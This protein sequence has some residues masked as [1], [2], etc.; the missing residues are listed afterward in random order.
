MNAKRV[1]KRI[2]DK[3]K[4]IKLIAMD[5]DGVLTGGEILVYECG[6]KIKELKVWNVRD[7][8]GFS[9]LR[10][11]K[12]GLKLAWITGR[13]C[14]HVA[15]QAKELRIEAF[16]QDC[17]D[18]GTAMKG[19]MKKFSL[20]PEQVLYIGDDLVDVPV[21]KMVGLAVAP[22]DAIAEVLSVADYITSVPGGKG[23]LREV[24]ELVL[25]AQGLWNIAA[26]K[27]L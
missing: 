24:V 18:K 5:V 11:A 16:V 23:V 6:S 7:R 13:Y 19:I 1:P 9:L 15:D 10:S 4:K 21:L 27:Y 8:M 3:A 25:K 12:S 26:A 20:K 2:I 17:M 22:N 14:K